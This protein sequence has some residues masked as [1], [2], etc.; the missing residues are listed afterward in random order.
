MRENV[1]DIAEEIVTDSRFEDNLENPN[2]NTVYIGYEP[3]GVLHL[4]HMVTAN[5]LIE[6]QKI[7]LNTKVLIAD[8]HA[9]LNNKSMDRSMKEVGKTMEEQLL[10]F[11]LSEDTEFV[12][13]SDFQNKI[14]YQD[15]VHQL[16]Q[17]V[18]RK[19]AER[20]MS[21]IA[22]S[23]STKVSH[24]LYPIMQIA[25]IWWL[26]ADIALGGM[27]QRKVHMLANDIFPKQDLRQ[28]TYIHTPLLA[29]LETGESKMSSSSGT[30][31]SSADSEQSVREKIMSAY[32]PTEKSKEQK[33][34]PILQMYQYHV[35]PRKNN[36]TVQRKDEHGGNV[37]YSSYDELETAFHNG[38]LH[39][40][41]TKEKLQEE[42]NDILE[43]LRVAH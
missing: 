19:R 31:I 30:T 24:L 43:P 3:S 22:D 8:L 9:D 18:S 39:P 41:D 29:D 28:R 6:L 16:C 11:G 27:E 4:G 42:L 33:D 10:N 25:D 34:N 7:G 40:L 13:G 35:F 36:V 20:S 17:K 12:Y 14:E 32:C 23:E 37:K 38:S 15:M 5:A 1:T 26:D 2:D 21:E